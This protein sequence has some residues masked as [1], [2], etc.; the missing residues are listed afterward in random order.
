MSYDFRDM[1]NAR[2]WDSDPNSRNPL[3]SEQLDLLISILSDHYQA[4]DT[5]LDLGF[6]SGLVEALIFERIPHAH[7]I[8]VDHS[9]AM[10]SLARERLQKYGAQFQSIPHDLVDLD[11][12]GITPCRFI[13]SSQALH[14]LTDAQM[15]SAYRAIAR[16]L[17]DDGL[18]L[19][20]DRIAA[21]PPALFD[22]VQSVWRWQDRHYGS[23][24]A[25]HESADYETHRQRALNRGDLPLS[26]P[27]HLALM[28]SAGLEGA[29]VHLSGIRAL[30]AARKR[31]PDPA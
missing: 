24:V 1:N 8:G 9:E 17:T 4:G 14:H 19:L 22:V 23:S 5:I 13:I 3:R 21:D 30:L 2:R 15:Q 20:L 29:C 25:E 27:R 11:S 10:M 28:R 16:L 6:G 18:F 26:L 7:I 31:A 12:V